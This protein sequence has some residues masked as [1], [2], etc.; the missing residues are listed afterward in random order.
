MRVVVISGSP[1]KNANTEIMM[2][3]VY[4]YA[5]A[6]NVGDDATITTF[7]N[8]SEGQVECFHGFDVEYNE[9]T[10][11]AARAITEADVWLIGTPI[12]NS[13]FSSALK[14]LFE[15]IDY[16]KTPGK[17]AG[18]AIL[19]AGGIGFIDVQTLLTQLLSYFRVVA[20]PK[21]V[22]VTTGDMTDGAISSADIKAKLAEMVDGTLDMAS[23]LSDQNGGGR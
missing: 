7:V 2:R 6:K 19:A 13:F 12:Y 17:T 1:R 3:Y 8:L 21:A 20:N 22:Y 18:M 16:K 9:Y 10:K 14:N 15:Y 23:R 4:E 5:K 11:S